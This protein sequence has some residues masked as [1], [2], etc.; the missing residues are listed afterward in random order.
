MSK[1]IPFSKNHQN[2]KNV[3]DALMWAVPIHEAISCPEVTRQAKFLEVMVDQKLA[4]EEMAER[5]K[6]I[7]LVPKQP[8]SSEIG[9]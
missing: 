5:S 7:S 8:V 2:Y 3:P 6:T 9:S 4:A 1:L